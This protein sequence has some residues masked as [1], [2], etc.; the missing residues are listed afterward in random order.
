MLSV[1]SQSLLLLLLFLLLL[2][3]LPSVNKTCPRVH[4]A[5][6]QFAFMQVIPFAPAMG[7]VE[8]N[9]AVQNSMNWEKDLG[10]APLAGGQDAGSALLIV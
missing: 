8:G 4:G 10:K 2:L 5:L 3:L 6:R 1:L 9:M 7:M